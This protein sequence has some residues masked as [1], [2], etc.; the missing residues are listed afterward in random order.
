MQRTIEVCDHDP[1]WA[2]EFERLRAHLWT[3]LRGLAASIEHVGSTSVPGLAAKPILDVDIIIADEATLQASVSV[4]AELGWSHRGD[5]GIPGRHAFT[6]HPDFYPH[7]LYVCTDD[8]DALRNHLLLRDHLLASADAVEEYGA[9]KRELAREHPHDIDAYV[10]GK[11]AFILGV[12]A[13]KGMNQ[14]VL[15]EIEEI[16][17][18]P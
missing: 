2:D 10:E 5:L 7:N 13:A 16:N 18:A 17:K 11:T 3:H 14:R 6:R 15:D 4:L 12:L 9:L 8:C 1:R